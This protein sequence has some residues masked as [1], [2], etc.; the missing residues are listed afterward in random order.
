MARTL[1]GE[2]AGQGG[3]VVYQSNSEIFTD[4]VIDIRSER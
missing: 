4:R 2:L 3:R 1:L